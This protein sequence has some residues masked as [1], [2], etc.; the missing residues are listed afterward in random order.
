MLKPSL[1]ESLMEK[2]KKEMTGKREAHFSRGHYLVGLFLIQVF[3]G[4]G[5]NSRVGVRQVGQRL[6]ASVTQLL[7][8]RL[9]GKYTSK[10][11]Q[12]YILL[13][14]HNVFTFANL[15]PANVWYKFTAAESHIYFAVLVTNSILCLLQH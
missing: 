10:K 11:F 4:V 12:N 5:K 3:Y 6:V 9:E 13:F 2:K 7:R 8:S 15:K 14:S 1:Y